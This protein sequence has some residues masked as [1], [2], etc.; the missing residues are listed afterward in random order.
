MREILLDGERFLNALREAVFRLKANRIN[1]NRINFFPVPDGDTGN[2]MLATIEAALLEAENCG[3]TLLGELAEAAADGARGS[4][5]GSSGAI[6]SQYLAGWASVLSGIETAAAEIITRA[7]CE[8]AKRAYRAVV[9]PVEG[10]ILTVAREA[11]QAAEIAALDHNV[12]A[13][14]YAAHQQAKIT[15]INTSKVVS[16]LNSQK[17]VDAGG[18]GLFIFF[19]ALVSAMGK[20]VEEEQF[21]GL[22]EFTLN[23]HE[24]LMQI[25]DPYD[26]ELTMDS[27]ELDE[28]AI[29]RLLDQEGSELIVQANN[30][31]GHIHIHTR[32]PLE[33]IEKAAQQ[34]P[35]SGVV[36][37]DMRRQFNAAHGDSD[38]KG[39]V[40]LAL[41]VNPGFLALFSL[42]GAEIA[43]SLTETKKI[44]RFIEEL[45]IERVILLSPEPL[46]HLKPIIADANLIVVD[47]EARILAALLAVSDGEAINPGS[48]VQTAHELRVAKITKVRDSIMPSMVKTIK[49]LGPE[50]GDLL[51]LYYGRNLSRV[52]IEES[53]PELEE[54]LPLLG[55]I[56]VYFGGQVE[57]LIITLE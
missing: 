46:D 36:I 31:C 51:T 49:G 43:L 24:Q 19:S 41:G 25:Y 38:S 11:A 53:L 7:L 42:A 8:G 34:A 27:T 5:S 12:T 33:V 13:T 17:V 22:M 40:A 16:T 35:V 15:L 3:S 30:Q 44:N 18:L 37:R 32:K 10:T 48:L 26:M 29:K 2:N 4:S 9:K 39:L 50:P 45:G 1:I 20:E 57:P 52:K 55:G 56:E 23:H 54:K 14:L 28:E 6:L 47:E 21:A